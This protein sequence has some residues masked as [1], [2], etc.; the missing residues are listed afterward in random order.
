VFGSFT[1]AVPLFIYGI[2]E[3][4]TEVNPAW[5]Y[6]GDM[7]SLSPIGPFWP[8][9]RS[10]GGRQAFSTDWAAG[11]YFQWAELLHP[12]RQRQVPFL[13]QLPFT[14]ARRAFFRFIAIAIAR[15]DP[16]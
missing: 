10:R 14:L 15:C 16:S 7:I 4:V 8:K 3:P 13:S 11:H 5:K 1:I 6:L 2:K 12:L 9:P